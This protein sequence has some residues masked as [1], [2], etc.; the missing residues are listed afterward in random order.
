MSRL[1]L[2]V[3]VSSLLVVLL[4][5]GWWVPAADA[6]P[7]AGL[8]VSAG[9][10]TD[11]V[12][13]WGSGFRPGE[14]VEAFNNGGVLSSAA[15]G[16]ERVW[17]SGVADSSGRVRLVGRPRPG[18]FTVGRAN[19]ISLRSASGLNPQH[20]YFEVLRPRVRLE[21]G[22]E[23]AGEL[24]SV[25]P[26]EP[27]RLVA[28]RMLPGVSVSWQ[29]EAA[30]GGVSA[31]RLGAAVTDGS[32]RASLV[33]RASGKHSGQRWLL[34]GVVSAR[35][36]ARGGAVSAAVAEVSRPELEAVADGA[37][38]VTVSGSG[39]V[40][41]MRLDVVLDGVDLGVS[42]DAAGRFRRVVRDVK[43]GSH[44]VR[45]EGFTNDV[46]WVTVFRPRLVSLTADGEQ[47]VRLVVE[48]LPSWQQV[49]AG[50]G[51]RRVEATA[52]GSGRAVWSARL[53]PGVH[54]V[55][56]EGWPGVSGRVEVFRPRLEAEAGR[57]GVALVRG[58]G[59]PAGA[60]L[61]LL[62]GE[63]PVAVSTSRSGTFVVER[64]LGAG[65]YRLGVEGWPSATG[66]V[67][68]FD[69]VV[70]AVRLD[71]GVEVTGRGFP[72]GAELRLRAGGEERRV[73][74]DA[75]GEV[76]VLLPAGAGGRVLVDGW[77]VA[78]VVVD[79]R[80]SVSA[81]SAGVKQVGL[82]SFVWGRTSRP[83]AGVRL[84]AQQG[85]GWVQVA[86]GV[87]DRQGRFVLPAR[88]LAASAGMRVFRVVARL[89]GV[90][91]SS[92]PVVLQR[93]PFRAGTAGVKP[94]G[95]R[96]FTWTGARQWAG[97]RAQSEVLVGGR[98]LRSQVVHAD[99]RGQIRIPLT[100]YGARP[101]TRQ[102]RVRVFTELGQAVSEPFSLRR[103]SWRA[104]HVAVKPVGA[105][106]FAWGLIGGAG[107]RRVQTEVWIGDRWS[108][109][110]IRVTDRQGRFV[111]PL[112]YGASRRGVL[113]W[114]VRVF[115][116]LGQVVSEPFTVIR[117]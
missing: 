95:A 6:V 9:S 113:R 43:A 40:A 64:R 17:L 66:Q 30:A 85:A 25:A 93:R 8:S 37:G 7:A 84:E 71:A 99:A 35:D 33:W 97:R 38:N 29:V 104:G 32:G 22:G 75:R 56:L 114:R 80:L 88:Y 72:A 47:L 98:W 3:V 91:A 61:R 44:W 48:G 89:D 78:A 81:S 65:R 34:R 49:V 108:R 109:S 11:S 59:F 70:E 105:R 23:A 20:V 117:R 67:D 18:L 24:V 63:T 107:G 39:F 12:T 2:R 106:T 26:G 19:W 102:W 27:V 45:A 103:T 58:A 54:D 31:E 42:S 100:A 62:V 4:A 14:R 28:D 76:R 116:E 41:S 5:G 68:V 10:W 15:Y 82:E 57:A 77:D 96:T 83:G 74:V 73:A 101:G 46:A 111:V 60:K 110:Q 112:T 53:E 13:V 1:R 115:T 51:G 55:R 16:R 87:S 21:A 86:G 92:A 69:P 79:R 36:R 50:L 94:V 52:G 90:T